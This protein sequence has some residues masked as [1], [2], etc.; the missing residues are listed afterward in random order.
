MLDC[1]FVVKIASILRP[2]KELAVQTMKLDCKVFFAVLAFK[3]VDDEF[4][5][6]KSRFVE[7]V[8]LI[9]KHDSAV[10]TEI[11]HEIGERINKILRAFSKFV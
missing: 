3:L 4:L 6:V 8:A 10:H 7:E 11:L 5:A 1:L 2:Y 9:C